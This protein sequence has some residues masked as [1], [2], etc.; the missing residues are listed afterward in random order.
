VC[1]IADL[2]ISTN[3]VTP[4]RRNSDTVQTVMLAS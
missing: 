1:S 2:D 3:V 4:G